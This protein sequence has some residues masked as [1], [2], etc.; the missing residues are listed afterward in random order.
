M[1]LITTWQKRWADEPFAA[2]EGAE[3]AAAGLDAR[4]LAAAERAGLI[5]RLRDGIILSPDAPA[6]AVR[7]LAALPQPFTASQARTALETTRRVA[8]PLL[9]YLDAKRRT[10]R[11]E[12]M[13]RTVVG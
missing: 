3:L 2:P 9:E 12:G 13:T 7:R 11:G 5:L 10:R 8:I 6:E 1:K 4:H